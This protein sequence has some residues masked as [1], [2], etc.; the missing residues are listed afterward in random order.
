MKKINE[1]KF[2]AIKLWFYSL[3]IK[4]LFTIIPG[5]VMK[6][7]KFALSLFTISFT[8]IFINSAFPQRLPEGQFHH[9]RNRDIDIIHYKAELHLDLANGSL[10][11]EAEITL[12]PLVELD[13][14]SLDAFHLNVTK[15]NLSEDENTRSLNFDNNDRSILFKLN[16]EFQPKDTFNIIVD[17]SCKPNAGMYFEEDLNHPGEYFEYTYGEGGLSANWLPIYNEVNDKFSTEMVVTVP[18]S[19]SVI[20]NGKLI[21]TKKE[22]GGLHTFHWKQDLPHSS[23]LIGVY[24]GKFEKG[25]LKP[26][27]GKIP[28]DYWVPDGK[29]KEGAY[30]FR[31]TTRMIDFFSK[32]F[33]YDFPWDKYDQVAMQDYQGAMENTGI[34]LHSRAILRLVDSPDN[35]DYPD[36]DH[37]N[38]FW[39][40]ELTI[41]H[42]LSHHWFG[43]NLTCRN[44]SYIWLNESF[45]SYCQQLWDEFDKGK[46]QLQFDH[47]IG[48]DRY[49]EFV[50]SEHIIRPLEYHYFEKPE[51][52][53][54]EPITYMKGSM[55]LHMLR[56]ILGDDN[57]FN[58]LHYY[59]EKNQFSNVTSNDLKMAIEES[60][61]QNLDWFFDDWVYGGGYPVFEVSY[62][63]LKDSK[64]VDL[65]VS[66][67][68]PIVEGQDLFKLP[69]DIRV[70]TKDGIKNYKL[71]VEKA[72]QEFFIK[73]D[74]VPLMVSFDGQGNLV[75]KVNFEKSV[76]ELLYQIK[77]DELPGKI[78]A[79]RQLVQKYPVKSETLNIISEILNGNY[80]WGLKAESTLLLGKIHTNEAEK[81]VNKALTS[82][83]YHIRKAAV[84]S[85][86]EFST[87]SAAGTLKDIISND[88]SSDVVAT[89]I[90]EL[91]KVEGKKGIDFIRQQINRSSWDDEIKTACLNA[92]GIIGD[93]SA[94]KDIKP[95]ALGRFNR[96]V[97][98]AGFTAW[99]KCSQNDPELIKSLLDLAKK[100][101]PGLQRLAINMLGEF[102]IKEAVPV[103]EY[104]IKNSGDKNFVVQA[105]D[106]LDEINKSDE[107]IN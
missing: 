14:F 93:E 84:L 102:H 101:I 48:L 26:A 69:V 33:N 2:L 71:R 77:H 40:S 20:S 73:S 27:L 58:A 107:V 80:F 103:F 30:T 18:D 56:Y 13:S 87:K 31:N 99:G 78:R 43:D 17:Y 32:K 97:R 15:A 85:L 67:V 36:F 39:T 46:E 5:V 8:I 83:D 24:A 47:Q 38:T 60:S 16:R 10:S 25:E 70:D 64:L 45:A 81:L 21:N 29:L 11:G 96:A 52:I 55:I 72:N 59:L 88:K 4:N 53:Y 44:L 35:F 94:V 68:Q 89:A 49:L 42:E 54:L 6:K 104:V 91:A 19:Y 9:D 37:Y 51:D 105:R 28:V 12:H 62:N 65:K 79:L 82:D 74:A 41:A 34:T 22:S 100:S 98:E 61:G 66:Q 76:N 1:N 75:A 23:Y 63:Y 92:F 50:E 86:S 95:L 7:F 3:I 57:F 90:V 106:V